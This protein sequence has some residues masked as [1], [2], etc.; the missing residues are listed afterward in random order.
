MRSFDRSG[1]SSSFSDNDNVSMNGYEFAFPASVRSL[2][3]LVENREVLGISHGD[4]PSLGGYFHQT[5]ITK[6]GNKSIKKMLY[7]NYLCNDYCSESCKEG[8]IS[9]DSLSGRTREN[10]AFF[11]F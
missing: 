10:L 7:E 4:A 9:G 6:M 11:Y 3:A 8:Q 1:I 5:N 2:N